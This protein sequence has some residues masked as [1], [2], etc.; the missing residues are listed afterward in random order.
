MKIKNLLLAALFC[1]FTG[2]SLQASNLNDL[3][4]QT[5]HVTVPLTLATLAGRATAHLIRTHFFPNNQHHRPFFS[6][7][8]KSEMLLELPAI[9]GISLVALLEH[10]I[11]G[12][13]PVI[14][15]ILG[16]S[17]GFHMK[18]QQDSNDLTAALAAAQ[19]ANLQMA[20]PQQGPPAG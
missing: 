16:T 11:T 13:V 14:A 7:A 3:W 2:N 10:K 19:A 15:L 4:Q 1:V 12:H 8:S 9:T 5:T 17:W 6:I 20:I 18:E